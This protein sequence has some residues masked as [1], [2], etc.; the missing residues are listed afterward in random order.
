[1][2]NTAISETFLAEV[3]PTRKAALWVNSLMEQVAKGSK[4]VWV[5]NFENQG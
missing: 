3:I 5:E 4:G 1:M 2:E